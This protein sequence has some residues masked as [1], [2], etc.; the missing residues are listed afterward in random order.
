MSHEIAM[1]GWSMILG[2]VYVM[3]AGAFS[4]SQRGFKW[5]AGNRDAPLPPLTGAA[6]RGVRAAANF[7]ETFPFFA[8]AVLAVTATGKASGHSALGADFYF[9]ARVVY[10]PTYLIGIPYLRTVVWMVSLIGIVMEIW[11]LLQ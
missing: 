8:A 2:L 5:N 6:A 11:V 10:L 3:T 9:W 4:T 7:M 1:L